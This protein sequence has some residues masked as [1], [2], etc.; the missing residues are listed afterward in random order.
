MI[1]KR[2]LTRAGLSEDQQKAINDA[3]KFLF[4]SKTPLL[5]NAK[6]LAA[7]PGIDENVKAMTDSIIKSS[8]H[9][10]GRYLESLRRKGH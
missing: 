7:K 8:S 5:E 6:A 2:G 9:R 1:N 4:R 10:F 3:F